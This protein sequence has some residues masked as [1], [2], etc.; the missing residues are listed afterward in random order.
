MKENQ[1]KNVIGY[2]GALFV[3]AMVIPQVAFALPAP[4]L[5]PNEHL[6]KVGP[7]QA[8]ADVIDCQGKAADYTGEGN[9]QGNLRGTARG[10]MKG[11]AAGAL[12][13]TIMNNSAGRGA[14]AGAAIGGL[15]AAGANRKERLEGSPAYQ[16]FVEGCLEDKGYKVLQW[17]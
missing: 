8:K 4:D 12:A 6:K 2:I 9:Q 14:G 16:K 10:A 1:R 13:G 11:A 5:Y 7:A 3:S 17:K 15:R